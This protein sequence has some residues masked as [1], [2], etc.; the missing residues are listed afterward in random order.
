MKASIC[1]LIK[2]QLVWLYMIQ[3][4][5]FIYGFFYWSYISIPII[6]M[7]GS[8]VQLAESRK[9]SEGFG[10][11]SAFVSSNRDTTSV[12]FSSFTIFTRIFLGGFVLPFLQ[13]CLFRS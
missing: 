1:R 3:Y 7:P 8:S 10:F 2:S 4:L 11:V 5:R 6:L 9:V 13:T 12:S